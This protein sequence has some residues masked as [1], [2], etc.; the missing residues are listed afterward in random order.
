ME[1]KEMTSLEEVKREAASSVQK[2]EV[3][4]RIQLIIF[5]LGREEYAMN[6]DQIKEVVLTPQVAK[7]PQTE[8]YIKGVANIRGNIIAILD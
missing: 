7:V 3:S 8:D 2:N 5:K 1:A 6:I 4:A